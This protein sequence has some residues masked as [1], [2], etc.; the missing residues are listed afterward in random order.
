MNI[1]FSSLSLIFVDI[2]EVKVTYCID[3]EFECVPSIGVLLTPGIVSQCDF[4]NGYF[5]ILGI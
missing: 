5:Y 2:D 4:H 3:F 1:N